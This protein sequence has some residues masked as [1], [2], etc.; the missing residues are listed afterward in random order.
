[1]Y[2]QNQYTFIHTVDTLLVVVTHVYTSVLSCTQNQVHILYTYIKYIIHSVQTTTMD[3]VC[4][5]VVI[6]ECHGA[7]VQLCHTRNN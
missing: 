6:N 2:A 4:V 1:M 3:I 7:I 5:R